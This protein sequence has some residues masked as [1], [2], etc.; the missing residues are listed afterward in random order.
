MR[1]HAGTALAALALALGVS[2][3]A[4]SFAAPRLAGSERPPPAVVEY[5]TIA[6][7][8]GESAGGHAAIRIDDVVHHLEHRGDGLLQDRRDERLAFEAV[9]RGRENREIRVLRLALSK[10]RAKALDAALRERALTRRLRLDALEAIDEELRWLESTIDRGAPSVVVPGLGLFAEG[11]SRCGP[12]ANAGG[13]MP[14]RAVLERAR[15]E[16]RRDR[17]AALERATAVEPTDDTGAFR[18]LL[19]ATQLEAALTTIASCRPVRA[20]ALAQPSHLEPLSSA[21][22]ASLRAIEARLEGALARLVASGRPD[23]GLAL[24]LAWSRLQAIRHGLATGRWTFVDAFAESGGPAFRLEN[25]PSGVLEERRRTLDRRFELARRDVARAAD[26]PDFERWLDRTERLAHD[27]AHAA[28]GTRHGA[29]GPRG[30]LEASRAI[31]RPSAR[32]ALPWP[33]RATLDTLSARRSRRLADRARLRAALEVDL[34]YDL[35]ERN[36]VTELLDALAEVGLE[37]PHSTGLAT[38]APTFAHAALAESPVSHREAPRPGARHAQV[39]AALAAKSDASTRLALRARESN[40]LTSRFYRPHADDSAFLFFADG[41]VVSR[42]F[43][44]IA[45]LAW[46]SG[47]SLVG[48]LTA[49]FDRG[50]ALRRGLHGVAL[51]LPELV[52]VPI[53]KGSYAVAVPLDDPG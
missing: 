11:P 49:P 6:A 39:G 32:V 51:S 16:A 17:D 45:N 44:G 53:R 50:V 35:V 22:T 9:Y 12:D 8:E 43:A 41:P 52:F 25:M 40:T 47:A 4:T 14:L 37:V 21:E 20:E 46:G 19:E 34:A 42:P 33:A 1:T 48:L 30:A 28:A 13:A 29:P 15:R 10:E 7:N 2:P 27:A 31:E 3:A 18:R 26:A 5:W 24:A 38:F 23:R 36:C